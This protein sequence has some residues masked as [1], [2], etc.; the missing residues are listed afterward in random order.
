MNKLLWKLA[1]KITGED[2]AVGTY[3]TLSMLFW[4][5]AAIFAGIAVCA[6]LSFSL[7]ECLSTILCAAAYTCLLAGL[8]GGCLFFKIGRRG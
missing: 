6:I 7:M 5:A 3:L 8:L 2:N 1:K 4:W